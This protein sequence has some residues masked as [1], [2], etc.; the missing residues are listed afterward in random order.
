MGRKAQVR[1]FASECGF[2]S[3]TC[4]ARDGRAPLPIEKRQRLT[5]PA[6]KGFEVRDRASRSRTLRGFG[7]AEAAR[8]RRAAT[9]R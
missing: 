8:C 3:N 9:V 1:E 2:S 5:R 6:A 7:F 4:G